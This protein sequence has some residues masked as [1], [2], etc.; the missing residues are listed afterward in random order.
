MK[1]GKL[2]VFSAPSGSGKTTIVRALMKDKDLNLKFS[3]SATN[4]KKRG[5][6]KD[7][8]DYFFLDTDTFKAKIKAGDFIEWEEVYEGRFYGSLRAEVEKIIN[9]GDNVAFDIDVAGAVE[10]KKQY[11]DDALLIFIKAPSL[12][13]LER[14]LR[15]R[16]TDSEADIVNRLAKAESETAFAEQFDVVI[17]NDDL[18]TAVKETTKVIKDFLRK[19]N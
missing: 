10:I 12:K 19:T 14:R 15:S 7:G 3:V 5:K 8:V 18:E 17:I 2:L 4:R 11:Q 16:N 6:E 1:R 13:E 9:S